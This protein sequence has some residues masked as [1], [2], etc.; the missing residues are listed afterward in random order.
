MSCEMQGGQLDGHVCGIAEDTARM[1]TAD[2]SRNFSLDA[3]ITALR[4]DRVILVRNVMEQA[5]ADRIIAAVAGELGLGTHLEGQA[6]FAGL[7]GHRENVSKYFMTVNRRKEFAI[8]LPHSEGSRIQGI[9]LASLYCHENSTDGGVSLL[10]NVDQDSTCWSC[11]KE[12]VTRIDP[13]SRPMTVTER[14]IARAKFMTEGA[15]GPDDQIL[16]ERPCGFDGVRFLWALTP[17]RKAY[18]RILQRE[19]FTYWDSVSSLD[20][21]SLR[22]CLRMMGSLGLLREPAGVAPINHLDP[23]YH[24][25]IWSSGVKYGQLFKSLI[26]RK[27][28]P[29][30]LI[31]QNN[32]TWTHAASNWTPG[33]GTRTLIA[34]FA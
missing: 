10:L 12:L 15:T 6:A 32:L 18:S 27:L 8:V 1:V 19:V 23:A 4:E 26:V 16:E 3:L 24:R 20:Y 17:A 29:G 21:D 31:I 30:D 25:A 11:L 34:A 14:A 5:E 33:S 9:Q 2:A 7:Q 22:E 13:Q 28:A